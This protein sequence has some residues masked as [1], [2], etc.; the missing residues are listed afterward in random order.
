VIV[1]DGDAIIDNVTLARRRDGCARALAPDT[2]V[3]PLVP[4]RDAASV[5][6]VR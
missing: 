6:D 3:R 2:L 5:G 4:A 1:V